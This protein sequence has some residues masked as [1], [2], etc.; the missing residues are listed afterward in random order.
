MFTSVRSTVVAILVV[1]FLSGAVVGWNYMRSTETTNKNMESRRDSNVEVRTDAYLDLSASWERV[2]D[3]LVETGF[4]SHDPAVREETARDIFRIA[5]TKAEAKMQK[6]RYDSRAV[7]RNSAREW[8]LRYTPTGMEEEPKPEPETKPASAP[9]KPKTRVSA[10]AEI[11]AGDPI[12]ATAAS[13]TANAVASIDA[14]AKEE[15][16]SLFLIQVSQATAETTSVSQNIQMRA[17]RSAIKYEEGEAKRKADDG[18][19]KLAKVRL[20]FELAGAK[21]LRAEL[22][23]STAN[24]VELSGEVGDLR[25]QLQGAEIALAKA[26]ARAKRAKSATVGVRL[27]KE[28]KNLETQVSDLRAELRALKE[29][30][31]PTAPIPA[32]VV[33]PA[34]ACPAGSADASG[35]YGY[36]SQG[37]NRGMRCRSYSTW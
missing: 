1:V 30:K 25:D 16:G 5:G 6:L 8:L 11:L 27:D 2:V 37:Y 13:A 36:P 26:R 14:W 33:N 34:A 15:D 7:V 23:K 21:Q 3:A 17:G 32:P 18:Q 29:A 31:V 4:T 12:K 24:E 22:D 9:E 19:E 28:V 35:F 10:S 20:Q